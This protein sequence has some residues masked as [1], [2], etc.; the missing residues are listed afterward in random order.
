[1]NK[2][3]NKILEKLTQDTPEL[4]ICLDDIKKA[5]SRLTECYEKDGKVMICGNGGSAADAEHIV[6]ELMKEFVLKRNIS[7]E[8]KKM[9]QNHFPEDADYLSSHLQG[10]LPA[11]SLVSQTS[12]SSAFAN[13]VSSDMVFAQQVYGYAKK[14]DVLIGLS[15][16]GN[17][18]NILDAVKVAKAFG[19][20]TICFTGEKGGMLKDICDVCIRVPASQ[21]YKVQEYHLMTYH[22]VC[23]I[24]EAEFFT[25]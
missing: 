17:S 24:I 14:G 6:G 1:M 21:T 25:E 22:A 2:Q 8:H 16:S 5:V 18:K 11:L 12:L 20:K 9:L 4:E 15:T 7:E 23:A 13:D 10:A 3:S 19:V